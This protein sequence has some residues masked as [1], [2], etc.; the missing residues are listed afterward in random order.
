MGVID[1]SRNSTTQSSSMFQ[2][3]TKM[4]GKYSVFIKENSVSQINVSYKWMSNRRQDYKL[5]RLL[6]ETI[7]ERYFSPL[8][9]LQRR[10]GKMVHGFTEYHR[11]NFIFRAHPKYRNERA[12]YDFVM[13]AWENENNSQT[14]SESED[15][16]SDEDSSI[17][18]ISMIQNEVELQNMQVS[19]NVKLVPAKILGFLETDNNCIEAVV[20]SCYEQS[21]KLLVLT[22]G[23]R[24]EFEN[25]D[26]NTK[27]FE[28]T[29]NNDNED[30]YEEDDLEIPCY[31]KDESCED[32]K[33]LLRFVSVDII[34]KHCL[35]LPVHKQSKYLIQVID[36]EKWPGRFLEE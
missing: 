7:V 13:L 2:S 15:E 19:K 1:V 3:G 18:S 25:D 5:P 33:P 21:R 36:Y 8:T 10:K 11:S 24:L 17:G 12:W 27:E 30:M 16:S 32:L 9:N 14:E 22:N 35:M 34:E 26:I 29:K 6:L 28:W 20:H 23:W 4:A 31:D